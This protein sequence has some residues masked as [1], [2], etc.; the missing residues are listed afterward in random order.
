MQETQETRVWLLGQE[1]PLEEGVAICSSI[2]AWRIPWTEEPGG[3][4]PKGLQRVGHD[5]SDWAHM[6]IRA[7][8][9]LE[10]ALIPPYSISLSGTMLLYPMDAQGLHLP[11]FRLEEKAV[12]H[13]QRQ[14]WFSGSYTSEE[15]SWS[16]SP[17]AGQREGRWKPRGWG[18]DSYRGNWHHVGAFLVTQE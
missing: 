9:K 6:H 13:W 4:Q 3:L 11:N 2:L 12:S 15:R 16:N 17:F 10:T 18:T 1:D 14:Q 8:L 5:W 7:S